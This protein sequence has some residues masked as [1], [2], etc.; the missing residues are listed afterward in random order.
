MGGAGK[1]RTHE[2]KEPPFSFIP[3]VGIFEEQAPQQ[4]TR[5]GWERVKK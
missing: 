2:N 3:P 5:D 1:K 4:F